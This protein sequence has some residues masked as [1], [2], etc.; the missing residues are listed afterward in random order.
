MGI[1]NGK[2]A[3]ITGGTS[4]IG[5]RAVE[6]FCEEGAK[7]AFWGRRAELGN[8]IADRLKAKGYDVEFYRV[9]VKDRDAVIEAFQAVYKRF[10]K[11]NALVNNAGVMTPHGKPDEKTEA[12]EAAFND[13]LNTDLMGEYYCATEVIPYLRKNGNDGGTIT[14]ISSI[15]AIQSA[16]GFAGYALAKCGIRGITLAFANTYGPENIRANGILPGIVNTEAV[17]GP[18]TM[19]TPG[20]D[21]GALV[22]LKR[23]AEPIDIARVMA[24]LASDYAGYINGAD[25]VVDGG[26]TVNMS[27]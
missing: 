3:V 6:F 21:Y 10:G 14:N 9:D 18:G 5:E 1:L 20:I 4:G 25:I 22:P 2:V 8:K 13:V 16:T 23:L 11:I 17:N 15:N 12:D 19:S 24:F 7:V 26:S 27:D